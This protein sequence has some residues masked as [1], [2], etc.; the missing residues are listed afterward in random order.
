MPS[1]GTRS[2]ATEVVAIEEPL[3]DAHGHGA[4]DRPVGAVMQDPRR[5]VD[6]HHARVGVLERTRDVRRHDVDARPS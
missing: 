2:P 3:K 6:L 1:I 4:G 5:R